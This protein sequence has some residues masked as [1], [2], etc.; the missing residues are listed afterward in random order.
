[1]KSYPV[2]RVC[3]IPDWSAVPTLS[4]DHWNTEDRAEVAA[5]AQ[6]A[7]DEER[8]WVHLSATETNLRMQEGGPLPRSWED[9][10]LEF[11]F[12]PMPGDDRYFN[13]EMTP[14]CALYLGVGPGN[15]AERLRLLP[16]DADTVFGQTSKITQDGWE[17]FYAIPFSFIRR[18]FPDFKAERGV[19]LRANCYK[20][21]DLTDHPHWLSWNPITKVPLSFH[22]PADFGTLIFE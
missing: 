5:W 13:I 4:I 6:I 11:F 10:C 12:C 3:G 2:K 21:G 17:L 20:C 16:K 9:S 8:L 7:Y 14:A 18:L 1:M 22:S 15:T 19:E